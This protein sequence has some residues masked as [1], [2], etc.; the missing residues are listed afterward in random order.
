ME[1][2]SISDLF[3]CLS[4]CSLNQCIIMNR[5]GG[6]TTINL[7]YISLIIDQYHPSN[8]WFSVSHASCTQLTEVIIRKNSV[9][10]VNTFTEFLRITWCECS[11]SIYSKKSSNINGLMADDKQYLH[12]EIKNS[13][14]FRGRSMKMECPFAIPED[15][16][17]NINQLLSTALTG[18]HSTTVQPPSGRLRNSVVP[19]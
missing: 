6:I 5:S 2:H 11:Y 14:I 16:K 19:P 9:N 1:Y 8:G 7:S 4:D 3:Y 18:M 15:R 17:K 12:A 10:I 13:S